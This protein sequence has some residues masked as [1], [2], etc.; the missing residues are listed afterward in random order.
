ML[1]VVLFIFHHSEQTHRRLGYVPIGLSIL[2]FSPSFLMRRFFTF[3]FTLS[4]AY[5]RIFTVDEWRETNS[6]HGAMNTI[7]EWA[8]CVFVVDGMQCMLVCYAK[9]LFN[10]CSCATFSDSTD[11]L[12][13]YSFSADQRFDSHLFWWA[14]KWSGT[15]SFA[16]TKLELVTPSACTSS[17]I[18]TG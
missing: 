12:T 1:G 5:V 13:D 2:Y 17:I 14:Y 11:W 18:L 15:E 4:A 9:K 8:T 16:E 7:D 6:I 10:L 3:L